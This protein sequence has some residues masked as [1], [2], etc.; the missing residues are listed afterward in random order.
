MPHPDNQNLPAM[1]A[2]YLTYPI[3]FSIRKTE[4]F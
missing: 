1:W 3:V 4:I 2:G